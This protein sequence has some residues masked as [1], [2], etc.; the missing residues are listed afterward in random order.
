MEQPNPLTMMNMMQ[1]MQQGMQMFGQFM[2]M[3]PGD[4]GNRPWSTGRGIDLRINPDTPVRH[5]ENSSGGAV[6]SPRALTYPPTE[7]EAMPNGVAIVG[8][9]ELLATGAEE[10]DIDA[11]I[12]PLKVPKPGSTALKIPKKGILPAAKKT[13]KKKPSANAIVEFDIA[14]PPKYGTPLP[15]VFNGCRIYSSPERYRVV[16]FPGKSVYDKAWLKKDNGQTAWKLVID[17]CKKA[18]IPK[19]SVNVLK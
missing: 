4:A 14:K 5:N 15:C 3:M 2:N 18:S 1:N 7:D 9:H 6:V 16:P 10:D 19:D 8:Q 13:I 17:Y 11:M 12:G